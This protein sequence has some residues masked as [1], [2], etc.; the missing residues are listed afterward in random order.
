MQSEDDEAL[1]DRNAEKRREGSSQNVLGSTGAENIKDYQPMTEEIV[2]GLTTVL[3]RREVEEDEGWTTKSTVVTTSNIDRGLMNAFMATLFGIRNRQTVIRWRKK[4]HAEISIYL[5]NLLYADKKYPELHGYFVHG[6]PG[7]ILDNGNVCF[8]VANGTPCRMISLGWNDLSI[9]TEVIETVNKSNEHVINIPVP[10]DFIIVEVQLTVAD[11][12]P[13]HLNLATESDKIHIPIG[14]KTSNGRKADRDYI[15]LPD[16]IRVT[17][18]AH[19]VDL[20]FAITT[21]KSQGERDY[22]LR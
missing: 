2:A 21:W 14:I 17:Y 9:Q 3:S 8:G 5:Q 20:S 19:A 10:P 13:K 12:W 18:I 7:Q 22:R 4:L 1:A 11:K 16:K 15:T 6:A